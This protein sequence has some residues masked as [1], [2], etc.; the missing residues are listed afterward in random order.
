MFKVINISTTTE[1]YI[2]NEILTHNK[3][4]IPNEINNST[5]TSTTTTTTTTPPDCSLN[6]Q[7]YFIN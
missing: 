2:A 3:K 4:P 1:T 5:T 6:I 7:A